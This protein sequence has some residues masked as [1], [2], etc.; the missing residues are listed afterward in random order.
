MA[1]IGVLSFFA[2]IIFLLLAIKGRRTNSIRSRKQF[3]I[4]GV[5]LIFVFVL[6]V[7][8]PSQPTQV[9]QA[10]VQKSSSVSEIKKEQTIW[11]LQK[12]N[13]QIILLTLI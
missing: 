8:D 9:N 5:L 2:F 10:T 13:L 11:N 4:S 7:L 3:L 12:Q 1:V 6:I